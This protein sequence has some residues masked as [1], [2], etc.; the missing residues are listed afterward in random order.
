MGSSVTDRQPR[1]GG[2]G[3]KTRS[4]LLEHHFF[5]A[6]SFN[7]FHPVISPVNGPPANRTI[8]SSSS[9]SAVEGT[10][11]ECS[12]SRPQRKPVSTSSTGSLPGPINRMPARTGRLYPATP[13]TSQPVMYSPALVTT[14]GRTRTD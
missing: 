11:T 9:T 13:L 7:L 2:R 10:R 14:S 1:S 6:V 3:S 8:T 5:P 4:R 12:H